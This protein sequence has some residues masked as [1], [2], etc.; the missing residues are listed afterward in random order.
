MHALRLCFLLGWSAVAANAE[1]RIVGSDLLDGK[2]AVALQE[3]ATREETRVTKKFTGSHHA[4]Q[5]LLAGR[6][7]LALLSFPP[8]Q[9]L[10]GEPWHCLPLAYHVVALLVA[11]ELPLSRVSC[12]R[13]AGIYGATGTAATARWADLGLRGDEA[14][15]EIIPHGLSARSGL[16]RA[17]V[18]HEV[19]GGR[20]LRSGLTEHATPQELMARLLIEEG[21]IGFVPWP[22]DADRRLKP[23]AVARTETTPAYEPNSENV[24][25]GDYPL[26]WPVWLV[27]RRAEAPL[28]FPLLRHLHGDAIAAALEKQGLLP[29]PRDVRRQQAFDLEVLK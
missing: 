15:R 28:L 8:G 9:A 23:L 14:Q 24:H 12:E 13:L 18:R 22:Q 3:V 7:D 2:F 17:L 19:L 11:G 1:W 25:R 5:E 6:A 21:S 29:L 26:R 20:D 4:W 10:P 16:S 27:F